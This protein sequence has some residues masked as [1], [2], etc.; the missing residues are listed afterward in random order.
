MPIKLISGGGGSVSLNPATTVSTVNITVPAESGSIITSSSAA[1]I[2]ASALSAGI[3]PQARLPTG[4]ILQVVS[5][6]NGDY[7]STTSTS[8][9]DINNTQPNSWVQ[10]DN[11]Q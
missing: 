6:R 2:N 7:F 11:T 5:A 10:I 4:S 1:G 9:T 3:L 8:W